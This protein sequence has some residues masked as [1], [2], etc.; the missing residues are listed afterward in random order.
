M[1]NAANHSSRTHLV[2]AEACVDQALATVGKHIVMALPLGLG[3]ANLIANAFYQRAL[4]DPEVSL[5]II[6]AL[7]LEIPALGDPLGKRFLEPFVDRLYAGVPELL[8]AQARRRGELQ[9][10]IQVSEF[11]FS[12]GQLLGHSDAQQHY[13]SSNYTHVVR[14]LHAAGVNVLA[15]MLAPHPTDPSLCSLSCNTDLSKDLIDAAKAKAKPLFCIGEINQQLPYMPNDAE[16]AI[17]VFDCVFEA[18]PEHAGYPLFAIP[19]QPVSLT[20]YAIA[21]HVSS[22]IEDGGTLQIGIGSL[23]DAI[24]AIVALRQ[25][26]NQRYQQLH[27]ELIDNFNNNDN[28][29]IN[30]QTSR[31]EQGLYGASEMLVEGLL[32]LRKHGVLTRTVADGI[33]C[34]GGFFAGSASFYQQLRTLAD[35]EK[36]G[37]DMTRIS[38]IN[39]LYQDETLKR[40]QRLQARFVNSAMMVSVT[41]AVVSDGLK[42]QQVVSGVGG[43]YNFVAQAHELENA[44]SII[45]LPSTR[46][47]GNKLHSN[48]VWEYNHTTIPR[49]L[50]DIIITEYGVADLRGLSDRDV[51]VKMLAISD[52]RFQQQLLHHAQQ[53]GKVEREFK[54]PPAWAKNLPTELDKILLQPQHLSMLAFFPL[55]NDFTEA[56]TTLA[57]AL[58]YLKSHSSKQQLL[59]ILLKGWQQ[60]KQSNRV[61]CDALKR[62]GLNKPKM[63]HEKFYQYL[64]LGALANS[65]ADNRPV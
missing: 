16:L 8:Y 53:A 57:I 11:F 47:S 60:R 61:W 41:G 43:Q 63:L 13:I 6:T 58:Q 49:H 34:H 37:I 28:V 59:K 45:C 5:H 52:A 31:F 65:L 27:D 4:Q 64:L 33:Y 42:E 23:G 2:N 39:Q 3:K 26:D 50:R 40:Q 55:A 30:R 20:Q 7:S 22:L 25:S 32:H 19:N 24:A 38:Y 9:S 36:R 15:Q 54:L 29:Q 17:S 44:R 21:L 18:C 56:E 62:M 46:A 51:I 48:I 35:S 14:D 1:S 10:N 12:P